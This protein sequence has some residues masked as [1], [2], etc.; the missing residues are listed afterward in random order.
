MAGLRIGVN[1]LYLIPGRVGGTEVYLR[2]LLAALADIDPADE[3][4]VFT[5]QETE[6]DLLPPRN[7][8]RQAPQPVRAVNRPARIA[9]EQTGLPLMAIRERLDLLLN[10]G[11]TS[12]LLCPCP[13]VT[14][15]HDLQHSRH[16]EHFRWFDLPFWRALLFQSACTSTALIAVSETTRNDLLHCY[17]VS[18]NKVRVVPHGVDERFFDIARLRERGVPEPYLLCVSTLHPHKNLAR[19]IRALREFHRLHPDFRLVLAG[20]RGFHARAVESLIGA[21]GLE[22]A[23]HITGWIPR[24]A[25]YDLFLRAHAFIYPST[26]EGFGLPVLEALAAGIPCACS[27]IK[28][29]DEIVGS[30]ALQFDP[31]DE[32]GILSAMVRLTSDKALRERLGRE[33]PERAACFSWRKAAEATLNVLRNTTEPRA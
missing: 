4:V 25:L 3:Y 24:E 16:P 18:P 20:M 29:L 32:A 12:P 8:F 31:Q 26:F 14:V 21:L 28:P 7:N 9:W 23:V 22:D 10:P 27:A 13:T 5:N 17:P 33:G 11:F 2:S 30:A 15:F 19:L 1:A 6:K